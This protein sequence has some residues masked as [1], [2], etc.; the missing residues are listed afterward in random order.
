MAVKPEELDYD[1][2]LEL[3]LVFKGPPSKEDAGGNT[4]DQPEYKAAMVVLWGDI[5]SIQDYPYTD[6]DIWKIQHGSK[7]YVSLFQQ[8][9]HLVAGN[10]R[11][12]V[13]YWSYFRRTYCSYG[14]GI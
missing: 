3:D 8:G 5:T 14:K 7:F 9:T 6:T 12:M 13:K 4:G 1:K 11:E 2:P 10:F